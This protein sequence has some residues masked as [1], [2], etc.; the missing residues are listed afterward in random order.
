MKSFS[1]PNL[2]INS[3]CYQQN[4][5][6]YISWES[7]N[8]ISLISEIAFSIF[9]KLWIWWWLVFKK[10][11][12]LKV[13]FAIL[14]I[15]LTRQKCTICT[16]VSEYHFFNLPSSETSFPAINNSTAQ[17]TYYLPSALQGSSYISNDPTIVSNGILIE[18]NKYIVANGPHRDTTNSD[19][20]IR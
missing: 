14:W 15:F 1:I 9:L 19:H 11:S 4:P 12:R 13:W 16:L 2:L 3:R 6:Q 8:I 18:H 10:C 20:H 17:N 7:M 5:K